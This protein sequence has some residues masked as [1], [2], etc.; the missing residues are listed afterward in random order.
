MQLGKRQYTKTVSILILSQYKP[1]FV[2][3]DIFRSK[4]EKIRVKIVSKKRRKV[5]KKQTEK[6]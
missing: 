6:S 2:P 4:E 1:I 3:I 5:R